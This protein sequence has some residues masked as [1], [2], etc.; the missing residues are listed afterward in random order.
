MRQLK[1][2]EQKLLKKV[3]FLR[4]KNEDNLREL[5]VM[6]RY[7]IQA[8]CACCAVLLLLLSFPDLQLGLFNAG[9]W[10]SAGRSFLMR[11]T[12]PRLVLELTVLCAAHQ[13]ACFVNS[14]RA[15][16]RFFS[17]SAASFTT[18]VCVL[19]CTMCCSAHPSMA[20]NK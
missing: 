17:T 1:H 9:T 15:A 6:R 19:T 2:H 18:L 4:W 7:H 8:R 12:V 10:S 11:C 14:Q 5:T 3:D 13:A 20:T 16:W